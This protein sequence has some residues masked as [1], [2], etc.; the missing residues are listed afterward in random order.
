M[1]QAPA[2]TALL[3][4]PMAI[5]AYLAGLMGLLYWLSGLKPLQKFF[6]VA[7]V[8]LFIYF[9]PTLSTAFG[10]TPAASPAYDWMTRYLLPLALFLLMLT[11][12][13]PAIA[14]LGGM[15]ILMML[16]GTLGTAVGAPLTYLV[17]GG[18]LPEDAWMGLAALSGSWIGGT[19]NL[20]AVAESVGTP[21]NIMGPTIVVDTLCGYGWM[22]VLL[23]F[24]AR[25]HLWD[26]RVN[27]QVGVLE[28]TNRRLGE[29]QEHQRP[30]D[31]RSLAMILA[32]GFAATVA[33]VS[34]GA[35]LPNVGTPTIISHTT[36]AI[37]IVVTVGLL[38]SLSPLRSLEEVGASRVGYV[39]L[40]LLLT[41]IG[42]QA[43]LR[44][45]FDAPVFLLAGLFWIII[46]ASVLLLAAR[47]LRAPLFFFATASMANIGGA[48]SA[49]IVA[50]VYQPAMAPVGLLM[51]VLGYIVGTYVGLSV[52][53]LLGQMAM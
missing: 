15:A 25:Q 34:A 38:L 13:L 47:L 19:A 45:I 18:L 23:A 50:S 2:T 31:T 35:R 27:A 32:L 33:A 36:W 14:R 39:A 24:S 1:N 41:G 46:H 52:A 6:D 9:I 37:L 10:I 42:A 30:I 43:D 26:R 4:D 49:P 7:P 44:A 12:D 28:E 53:W 22:A 29:L 16:A 17:F 51:A 11:V 48:V 21:P 20:V 8:I 5:F 40:Y 3:T